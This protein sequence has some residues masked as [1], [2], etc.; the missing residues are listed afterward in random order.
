MPAKSLAGLALGVVA[1]ALCCVGCG[2]PNP[3]QRINAELERTGQKLAAVAPLS[4]RVT[5]DGQPPS[6]IL[7]DK[8]QKLVVMLCDVS[9]PDQRPDHRPHVNANPDG[10]FRFASYG[11]DDGVPPATYVFVFAVLTDQRK[12]G[13]VGPDELKNLYNDPEKNEKIPD[14]KI[15]HKAPGKSDYE[16]NLKLAGNENPTPGS[17]ALTSIND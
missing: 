8:S 13:Y 4:G 17:K 1:L 16:F 12:Q 2:P 11:I 14:F 5:I 10:S 9:K 7:K 6:S 15:D 3:Q